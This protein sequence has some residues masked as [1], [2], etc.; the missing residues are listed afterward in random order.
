MKPSLNGGNQSELM[1][2]GKV[3]FIESLVNDWG[4]SIVKDSSFRLERFLKRDSVLTPSHL[5]SE[6]PNTS[7]AD[8]CPKFS[9]H[10]FD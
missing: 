4:D 1:L 8:S 10:S 9:G 7:S 3:T 2:K 6:R 5:F